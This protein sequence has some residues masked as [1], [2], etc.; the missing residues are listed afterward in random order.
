MAKQK[1]KAESKQIQQKVA[2]NVKQTQPFL[3]S[4][5]NYLILG[6]GLALIAIGFLLMTGGQ[7]PPNQ[8]DP[9]V[10]YSFRRTTLSTIFV[11]LGF[12]VVMAS[13][14]WKRKNTSV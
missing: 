9:N 6:L 5:E 13:I 14:F 1:T 4:R 12:G 8:F 2:S 11:L 3:F 10:I 7:Q